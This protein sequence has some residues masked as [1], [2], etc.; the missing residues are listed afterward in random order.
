[1]DKYTDE[2]IQHQKEAESFYK[3]LADSAKA[4]LG[5]TAKRIP[6]GKDTPLDRNKELIKSMIENGSAVKAVA[7]FFGYGYTGSI[8]R[9]CKANFSEEWYAQWI[10]P[11]TRREYR[12]PKILAYVNKGYSVVVIARIMGLPES[13]I[14]NYVKEFKAE[15]S[16]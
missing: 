14:K 4:S 7:H 1:M 15:G 3:E 8:L 6:K 13:T 12:K 5:L 9:F 11:T 10:N 16:L 2:L